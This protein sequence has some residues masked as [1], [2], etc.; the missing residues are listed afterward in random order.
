MTVQTTTSRADYTGNGTTTTFAVPFYFLDNTH[1]KVLRTQVSTGVITTLTLTT[2]YTVAGVG[3]ITGGSI[4]CVTAP[5]SD[6]KISILRNV[7]F[8]QLVDYVENDPFPANTHERALDQLT[9]ETQQLNEELSRALTLPENSTGVSTSLPTPTA[10]NVIGWN[11]SATGLQNVDQATLATLVASGTAR[12]DIFTGDGVTTAFTLTSNPGN[13]ASLDVSVGGVTQLPGTD[14]IWTSGTLL[15]FTTAPA[16]GVKVLVKYWLGLPQNYSDSATTAFS[17]AVAYGQGTVGLALQGAINV[18]NAPYNAVGDGIADDTAAIQAALATGKALY[19]PQPSA[20]YNITSN[21]TINVPFEAG[22][23]RVF[24]GSGTVTL[25]A[26]S[27]AQVHPHWW[28][29]ESTQ[30]ATIDATVAAKNTAA[31]NAAFVQ[32]KYVVLPG[33]DYQIN[34]TIAIRQSC[35]GSG[36]RTNFYPTGNFA[37]TSIRSVV[38]AEIGLFSVNYALVA[39]S[40]A[41]VCVHVALGSTGVNDQ[42]VACRIHHI[43]GF[44]CYRVVEYLPSDLGVA[45]NITLDSVV[46]SVCY[47]RVVHFDASSGASTLITIRNSGSIN[48]PTGKGFYCVNMSEVHIYDCYVDGGASGSGNLLDC[49]AGNIDVDGFHVEAHTSTIADSNSAPILLRA[50]TGGVTAKNL[51]FSVWTFTPGSAVPVFYMR[52]EG[53]T[54][55]GAVSELSITVNNSATKYFA[56]VTSATSFNSTQHDP[57]SFYLAPI[58]AS[59]GVQPA[60]A[61][62]SVG[63][64]ATTL[65]STPL[66]GAF[67]VSQQCGL[68]LVNGVWTSDANASFTDL[69]LVTATGANAR[70]VVVISSNSAGGAH[71]RTYSISGSNIQLA[72]AT[73]T[74]RVS[75]KGLMMPRSRA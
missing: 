11:A 19:F 52:C 38:S 27:V 74:Y 70:T 71:A 66:G 53:K 3:V 30:V 21:I 68:F 59:Y 54:E 34:G 24:G 64:S 20:Y 37:A 32:S 6:Q 41:N 73:A 9:M 65:L 29:A 1:I 12:A 72:M 49:F 75:I 56:N 4:T 28:G 67:Q 10:N 16:I 47:D 35:N 25:G 14:Y 46:A 69:I 36:T 44:N 60:A 48:S 63:T 50:S 58:T 8:T 55:I 31:F 26:K 23:Y 18:K 62:I 15:T 51:Y 2:D 61:N 5:T 57:S 7:P 45:W 22:L 33:G 17:H 39:N 42:T 13:Q 43:Y 40:S